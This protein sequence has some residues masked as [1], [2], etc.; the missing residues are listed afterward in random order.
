MKKRTETS[1]KKGGTRMNK[2]MNKKEEEVRE[3]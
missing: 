1:E 2:R 3:Q